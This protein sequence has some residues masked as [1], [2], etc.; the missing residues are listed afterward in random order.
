MPFAFGPLSRRPIGRIIDSPL[1]ATMAAG[2]GAA[3][4]YTVAIYPATG[5]SIYL[6][7]E[8]YNTLSTDTLPNTPFSGT[9]Q[10]TLTFKRSI[11]DGSGFGR[12]SSGF[13]EVVIDNP[14]GEYD[15]FIT[16]PIAGAHITCKLG[17]RGISYD[18]FI[19]IYD[20]LIE[21]AEVSEDT[22]LLHV[23]DDNK[24]LEIPVQPSVYAGA[25]GIDGDSTVIGKRKP[26]LL[27]L[28]ANISPLLINATYL[29][30][31]MHDGAISTLYFVYDRGVQLSA[32]ATPDYADY[33]ALTGATITPGC[34][35]TCLALGIFRLGAKAD[36]TVTATAQ[37][38][39]SNGLVAGSATAGTVLSDTASLVH[40]LITISSAN[41]VVDTGSIL[42]FKAA[43]S[44]AIGYYIS[45]DDNK[46][47]R[48]AIDELIGGMGGW[49][50]FRR[51]RSFEIGLFLLPTG[52]VSGDY[53]TKDWFDLTREPLPSS[54]YPPPWRF[55]AP[56]ARNWTIQPEID[57]ALGAGSLTLHKDPY[58]VA[59]STDAATT[60]LVLAAYT[61][62]VAQDPDIIPAYFSGASGQANA[63]TECNRRLVLYGGA[64][65]SLYR[66]TLPAD[67]LAIPMGG[68]IQITYSRFGLSGGLALTVVS[69]ED[70]ADKNEFVL[71]G[72]G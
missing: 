8:Q 3:I 30:Y 20:G 31:Q 40:Y 52:T 22:V 61:N 54:I 21:N 50:G 59:V 60:A 2:A 17:W 45:S 5:S 69:I 37:G 72:F 32:N 19:T 58:S 35:A 27:G 7:T 49:S 56:Y 34:Y 26:L 71:E 70:N 63:V 25:G 64:A 11:V 18:R 36:G 44:A 23:K 38:A 47:L 1:I 16:N 43:Q 62:N 65:R 24:R 67:A 10:K 48:T 29:V 4:I 53:T 41:I 13:G 66:V 42:A 68:R 55:R 46:T 15:T 39:V 14:S 12:M 57:A 51:D 33:A 28:V 9:L 6:A